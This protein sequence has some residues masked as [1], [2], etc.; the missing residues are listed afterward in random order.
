[1]HFFYYLFGV[2]LYL[3]KLLFSFTLTVILYDVA[4]IG[5]NTVNETPCSYISPSLLRSLHPAIE[6]CLWQSK[7]AKYQS[8]LLK[9]SC[10]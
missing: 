3:S 8:K 10:G 6:Q 7:A 2:F 4:K 1:M 9:N 5:Q